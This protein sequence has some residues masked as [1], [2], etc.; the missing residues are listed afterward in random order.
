[1]PWRYRPFRWRF[2]RPSADGVLGT[3]AYRHGRT[4]DANSHKFGNGYRRWSGGYGWWIFCSMAMAGDSPSMLSTSGFSI[5]DKTGERRPINSRRSGVVPSAYRVSK[6]RL[7]LPEPDKPVMTT[8]LSRGMSMSMFL[9]LWV[10]TPRILIGV[11]LCHVGSFLVW[12][13]M[14]V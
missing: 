10:H 12:E 2:A 8:S 5:C 4:A 7:D 9:R 13:R 11:V 1:M 14:E 6:A 3:W